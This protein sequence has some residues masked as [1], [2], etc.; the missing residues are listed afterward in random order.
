MKEV[1]NISMPQNSRKQILKYIVAAFALPTFVAFEAAKELFE[2]GEEMNLLMTGGRYS[3]KGSMSKSNGYNPGEDYWVKFFD[4]LRPPDYSSGKFRQALKR[5]DQK[6][7]I[8]KKIDSDGKVILCL[9]ETGKMEAYRQFPF[10]RLANKPWKGWWLVVAFDIP[11][12]Q[13]RIRKSIRQQLLQIGF[14]Q[15]Q[16]SVYVSPHDISDDL[17]EIIKA[18]NLQTLVV[19]MI[20]KRI[21]AGDDWIFAKTLFKIDNI[22][23]GYQEIIKTADKEIGQQKFR[24]LMNRYLEILSSDPFIPIGLGPK[25]GYGR[26]LALSMLKNH[27]QRLKQ[28]LHSGVPIG[29]L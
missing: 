7:F 19:P 4:W 12:S 11:E 26:E 15:W 20:A 16:K 5:A 28:N 18:N 13:S 8:E 29:S 27:A 22:A 3:G 14:A 24:Y 10:F 2:F 1:L 23:A 6:Q 21:L 9:T 25:N 17:N